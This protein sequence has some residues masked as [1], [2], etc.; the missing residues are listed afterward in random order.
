MIDDK[1]NATQ[2]NMAGV[3]SIIVTYRPQAE[4]LRRLVSALL[5]EDVLVIVVDNGGGHMALG[6]RLAAH[7][8]VRVVDQKLNVGIGAAINCGVDVAHKLGVTYVITFDQDSEPGPGMVGTL[9][10]EFKRQTTLGVRLGAVGP[11]FVDSRQSPPLTHPFLRLNAF[12]SGHRYCTCDTELIEVDCLITSGCLTSIDVL[13]EVG[14]MN[15]GYFVDYTDVEWCFRARAK[16]FILLGVCAATMSHE[17]GH[18]R[19]R[20]LW[21]LNLIEYGAIRRYY[22]ARNTLIVVAL[23]YVPWRWKVRFA[24]GLALRLLTLPWAP[25]SSAELLPKEG[26]MALRGIRDGLRGVHGEISDS[27]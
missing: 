16:G 27:G 24:I 3:A 6:D 2:R 8:S 10:A 1:K 4:P 22:Y 23:R 21:K 25:R 14:G 17:L 26:R 13:R 20:K 18:G 11:L 15:P 5:S 7:P 19:V 12:G 9:E